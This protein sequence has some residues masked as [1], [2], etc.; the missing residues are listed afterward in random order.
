MR[1]YKLILILV[2]LCLVLSC[3][4]EEK[5][6]QNWYKG[7]LHTHSYWSDGDDFPEMIMDWYQ[8]NGYHFIALSDHNVLPKEEHWMKISSQ[9]IYQQGFKNYLSK[10]GADWVEYES[11]TSGT[12]VR[13]KTLAEYGPLFEKAGAFLMLPAEEIS[14]KFN[15]S[16]LH[17]NATNIQ[18]RIEPQG[19][20]STVEVLQNNINAV[21][22]QRDETSTRMFPHINHPNFYYAISLEDM[23]ALEGERFFEVFNGHPLVNNSGDSTHMSTEQMWDRINIAYSEKGQP[24][25]YGIA[26]DDSHNYHTFGK[27]F[28]NAG[29]GWIMVDADSLTPESLIKAMESG[30]FYASTGVVLEEVRFKNNTLK[31]VTK[32]EPGIKYTIQFV[33]V[34]GNQKEGHILSVFDTAMAEFQLTED[35]KFVRAKIISDKIRNDPRLGGVLEAAWTQPVAYQM[36]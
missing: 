2:P 27:E 24:L 17:L 21:L 8:S 14:D 20:S 32:A 28:S 12:T 13:L 5:V 7:N 26:T 22:R 36:E 23:I 16:P 11:D 1:R 34:K 25:M 3:K 15:E 9:E 10:F 6:A 31:V 30:A 18:E 29:R 19:G 35:L 33:G 4:E